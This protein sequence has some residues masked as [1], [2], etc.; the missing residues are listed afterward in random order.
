MVKL[1]L[2]AAILACI[3][4]SAEA[5]FGLSKKQYLFREPPIF[6]EGASTRA[7]ELDTLEQL[8]DNFDT[9]NHDTYTMVN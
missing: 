1:I 2:T 6:N 3:A 7:V 4:L 5:L 8:V 9:Q